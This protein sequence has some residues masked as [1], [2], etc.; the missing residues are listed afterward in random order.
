MTAKTNMPAA[1]TGIT[2]WPISFL[3]LALLQARYSSSAVSTRSMRPS[4]MWTMRSPNVEDAAVVRD[5][6]DGPAGLHG[7]LLQQFHDRLAR[8]GVEGRGRLVAD[9]QLRLVN[10]G[11]GDGHALLLA[12]GQLRRAAS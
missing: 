10:Q 12:A 8:V 1:R 4:L 9:Q 5:H 7:H 6:D 3:I 11:A 2:N